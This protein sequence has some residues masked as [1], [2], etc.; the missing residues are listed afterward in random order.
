MINNSYIKINAVESTTVEFKTSLFYRA[1]ISSLSEE[2]MHVIVRTIASMMNQD[3]GTLYI[4]VNDGGYATHDV[5]S[6]FRYLT[7]FAPSRDYSYP[8]NEDGYKRFIIDWVRKELNNF[9]TTLLSFD[10]ETFGGVT[11]CKVGIR[12]SK[13][14]V[15]YE[16][17][18]LYVRADA[19]TRKLLGNDITFFILQVDKA[20]F[21]GAVTSD[22]AA[23][24]KRLAAIKSTEKANGSLLVVYPNGDYIH[25]QKNVDVLLEVI[26]RAGVE[27]VRD[28]G[29]AGRSGR[30]GTPYVPFIGRDVYIDNP[31]APTKTQR[32]LDGYMVF[33]K[34]GRGDIV[35]KLT[36]ISNGLGLGLH[37]E[38]F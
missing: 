25:G 14:P 22:R 26:R 2:Q 17:K 31:A 38:E 37:I 15:W 34:Y 13:V 32:E 9:A 12:K 19:S 7:D 5:R 4:G 27:A 20:D 30:R 1:G 3:G 23:F 8:E 35:S 29:L 28:L 18:E 21:Q 16:G 33:T 11:I 36:Q 24:E 6:E 10:F